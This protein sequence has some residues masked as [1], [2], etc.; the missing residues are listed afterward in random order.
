LKKLR[1]LILGLILLPACKFSGN[2]II[3]A[4]EMAMIMVDIRLLEAGNSLDSNQQAF[5]PERWKGDYAFVFKKHNVSDSQFRQSYRYYFSRP[6]EFQRIMEEA[7]TE[8]QSRDAGMK[9]QTP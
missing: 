4:D 8:L 3:P 7:I 5:T 1:I 6:A 2:D 9:K